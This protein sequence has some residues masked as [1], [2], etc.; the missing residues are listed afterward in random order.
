M[1][2]QHK[3]IWRNFCLHFLWTEKCHFQL[4][5][6]N[7]Y[8]RILILR[9]LYMYIKVIYNMWHIIHDAVC[10]YR[11][12]S[13]LIGHWSLLF[14][15]WSIILLIYTKNIDMG[16]KLKLSNS[17]TWLWV[18][19]IFV[20]WQFFDKIEKYTFWLFFDIFKC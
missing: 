5:Y 8:G 17:R 18:L 16:I 3:K 7:I 4:T 6:N 13:L 9:S 10:V 1:N 15:H 14:G 11:K 12:W 19:N 2:I 20:L